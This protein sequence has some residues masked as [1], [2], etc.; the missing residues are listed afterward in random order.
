MDL[1]ND[2]DGCKLVCDERMQ[3]K[4]DEL[5]KKRDQLKKLRD[6]VMECRCKLP[7][8]V[9]VEVKRT[10]SLAA[11]CKCSPEDKILVF[12]LHS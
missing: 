4:M 7:I 9:G 11:L 2:L 1:I 10:P 6:K 12:V 3:G 8:S 5:N